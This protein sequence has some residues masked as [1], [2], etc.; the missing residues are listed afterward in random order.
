VAAEA[1]WNAQ[2]ELVFSPDGVLS[3]GKQIVA[4]SDGIILERCQRWV[5]LTRIVIVENPT[6]ASAQTGWRLNI[7]SD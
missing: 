4:T 6:R 2:V 7:S 5:N 1:G 3:R